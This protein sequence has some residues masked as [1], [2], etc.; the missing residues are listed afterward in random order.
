[1]RTPH[2]AIRRLDPLPLLV[3][4]IRVLWRCIGITLAIVAPAMV[5]ASPAVVSAAPVVSSARFESLDDGVRVVIVLD[6]A[7]SYDVFTLEHPDRLVLDLPEVRWAPRG[8]IEPPPGGLVQRIRH[9]R[10]KEGTT[11]IVV[12]CARAPAVRDVSLAAAAAGRWRLTVDLADG[13]ARAEASASAAAPPATQSAAPEPP[14]SPAEPLLIGATGLPQGDVGPER[15]PSAASGALTPPTLAPPTLAPPTATAFAAPRP[16]PAAPRRPVVPTWVVAI[17]PGHGG[18]DP[19]AI[20]PGGVYEKTL[21]LAAARALREELAELRRYKVVLTRNRDTFVPLRDR[22]AIA[23]A[24]GADLFVSLHAD[25]TENPSIRGLSIYTL[26]ERASD[27]EAAALAEKEN[28]VDLLSGVRL[29]G[30]SQE[31]TNILIDLAQRD[32]MN[33]SAQMASLLVRELRDETAL[34]PKTHRFAGFAVLKAPDVPSA[35][36]EL[37][38]LSNSSDQSLL[39]DPVHRRR[40]A[41]A[42]ARAIDGYFVSWEARNRP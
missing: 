6:E 25:K 30:E 7:V 36:I 14:P 39:Q 26:S 5:L 20:G 33:Q 34:L 11:R 21:T 35:L 32:T 1:M 19:G 12:D 37:G 40:L 2:R 22:I 17:D 31:V 28:K 18:Q 13:A 38:Y 16:R 42:I 4:M 29:R 27:A 15:R 3:A 23:R 10:F 41:R 24:A 8:T 9:G